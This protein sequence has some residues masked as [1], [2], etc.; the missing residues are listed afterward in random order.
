MSRQG[1]NP[2]TEPRP[3][4]ASMSVALGLGLG[5]FVL[6]SVAGVLGV[7]LIIGYQNTVDLLRQKSELL[8][9]SERDLTRRFLEAAEA[10]V[11]FVVEQ[12]V[13]GDIE[14]DRSEEFTS[15]LLGALA[16]TP[17][18]VRLQFI[19]TDYRVTGA[20]RQGFEAL[21]I[22]QKI[23][24]DT[25]L[26]TLFDKAKEKPESGWGKL[27]W[28]QEYGQ[29]L[30]NYHRPVVRD[31]KFV[32]LVSAF[33]SIQLLSEFISDLETEFGA[34]AFILHGRDQVL[35]HSLMSFGYPGL[36]RLTPLPK[37]SAFGDP[38]ITAMWRGP[39][40]TSLAQQILSGPGYN[41]V[42]FGEREYVVLHK[43]LEGYSD[44]PLLIGTYFE[45]LDLLSEV[46]RLK[47]AIVICLA[48]SL[49]SA[50]VAAVIGR[51]IAQP[52]RRLADGTRRIHDLELAS[53]DPIPGS[54]FSE[55]DDAA[56]SFNTMLDGLRWFERYVP[57]RLV[58]R[59]IKL[60]DEA[61]IG[62][63]YRQV[64]I[65]FTD[66]AGF[67]SLSEQ[68]TAPAAAEY[69][70]GHFTMVADCCEREEGTVDKFIGDSVMAIW[71][72]PDRQTDFAD[73][74]C[75]AAAE[76]ARTIAA[77]NERRFES[78]L[79]EPLA[80]IRI[81]IHV[82]RVVVGNIGSPG[83]V[84]YTV[85]GDAVNVAQRLTEVADT[86]V[87]VD[88]DVSILVTSA[89]KDCLIEPLEL[90]HIGP[91]PLRGRTEQVEL[92]EIQALSSGAE[93]RNFAPAAPKDTKETQ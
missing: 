63:E 72:A 92:Y 31:K 53:V 40:R 9:A 3:V 51:Q 93:P 38:V 45:S 69:L 43:E 11:D 35:A 74:A 34:N 2:T 10:Q 32:G 77:D 67:T 81:G 47:W 20:E 75:R 88:R 87:G 22:F 55:L 8:V 76:V 62:S 29:A 80:R 68:M 85:I 61:G 44:K 25:E 49:F 14:A 70:N 28:R 66:M 1:G 73:R 39:E 36:T 37:Q 7:G 54:F 90:R 57:K 21:P 58:Q 15:L 78:D 18:I 48:M 83:R 84:N 23:G 27:L 91:R 24:D 50:I 86:I 41:F 89:V 65:M 33:V 19:S 56:R 52:V 17:Q 42:T 12:L 6:T 26:R 60:D 46:G 82:G 79:S 59:L 4:R 13:S 5:F 71:G 64:V 30:L 16:A